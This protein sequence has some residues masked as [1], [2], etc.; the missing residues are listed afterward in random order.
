L[1]GRRLCNIEVA[2]AGEGGG[3][4]RQGHSPGLE[5][6]TPRFRTLTVVELVTVVTGYWEVVAVVEVAR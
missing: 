3:W 1:C 6:L 5:A 2:G 4:L